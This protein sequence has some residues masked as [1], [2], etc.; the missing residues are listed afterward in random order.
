MELARPRFLSRWLPWRVAPRRPRLRSSRSRR[1]FRL[2]T[3]RSRR[4]RMSRPRRVCAD[5][6]PHRF[7]RRRRRSM[8]PLRHLHPRHRLL[9]AG[10]DGSRSRS[11]RVEDRLARL[12]SR[13]AP[14]RPQSSAGD[15]RGDKCRDNQPR[16]DLIPC[17]GRR[18]PNT[19]CALQFRPNARQIQ[20]IATTSLIPPASWPVIEGMTKLVTMNATE[21]VFI[22][23][24]NSF[25]RSL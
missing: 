19:N 17:H 16:H 4:S 24:A 8:R 18:Y 11:R 5:R 14:G 23:F 10:R 22:K 13:Y 9:R 25:R 2:R 20:E 6:F 21:M 3:S 12:G 1:P 7:A 15:N